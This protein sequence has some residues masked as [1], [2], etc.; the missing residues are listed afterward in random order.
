MPNSGCQMSLI[1]RF[2]PRSST[3]VWSFEMNQ[4]SAVAVTAEWILPCHPGGCWSAATVESPAC[5]VFTLQLGVS[6]ELVCILHIA[7]VWNQIVS[8]LCAQ[9]PA[10][11]V[12]N[13]INEMHC[14]PWDPV[15]GLNKCSWIISTSC[16]C[17]DASTVRKGVKAA[18][19]PSWQYYR[20]E[21]ERKK[22]YYRSDRK[23]VS[24]ERTDKCN[25]SKYVRKKIFECFS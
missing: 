19:Q 3:F 7:K 5:I 1:I 8:Q 20:S 18:G 22:I 10:G 11:V 9:R 2:Q 12:V 17:H 14:S 21:T 13:Q 15:T 6:K 24:H 25:K 4:A 16:N 23:L